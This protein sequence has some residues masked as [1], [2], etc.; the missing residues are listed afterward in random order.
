ME[1]S[2]F[3]HLMNGV[4]KHANIAP[5]DN[6]PH[7]VYTLHFDGQAS[8]HFICR[9]GRNVD[10]VSE[11][12]K[13]PSQ[14]AVDQLIKLL[15]LNRFNDADFPASVTIHRDTGTLLVW[16]RQRLCTLDVTALMHVMEAVRLKTAAALRAI[17]SP[18]MPIGGTVPS[19]ASRL[20]SY[21]R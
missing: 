9:D 11:V 6:E 8:V 18:S 7:E 15:A 20:R 16:N 21:F 17:G 5:P 4:M 2:T 1:K 10:V 12:G 14:Q 3:C 13:L 19:T